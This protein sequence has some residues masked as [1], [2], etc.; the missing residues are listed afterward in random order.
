M[1][2]PIF[3]PS[4]RHSLN[5]AVAVKS[6]S[7]DELSAVS[8]ESCKTPMIKPTP[9]TFIATSSGIPNKLHAR[10]ISNKD[11]PATPEAPQAHTADST[12]RMIAVG[13]ST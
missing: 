3:F 6:T 9:T 2:T 13:R 1:A 8:K 7:V 12:L 4:L 5:S 11:P 10:G